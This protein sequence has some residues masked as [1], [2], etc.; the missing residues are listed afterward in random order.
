MKSANVIPQTAIC[1]LIIRLAM[2]AITGTSEG[3][4]DS[5]IPVQEIALYVHL[6]LLIQD[7]NV[8]SV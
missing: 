7:H 4:M 3:L 8:L 6:T 2:S 5:V 1:A